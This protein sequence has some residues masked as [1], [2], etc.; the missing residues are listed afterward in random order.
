[1][2][3][4]RFAEYGASYCH[5]IKPSAKLSIDPCFNAVCFTLLVEFQVGS[6]Y[7]LI[8]PGAILAFSGGVGAVMK[9]GIKTKINANFAGWRSTELANGFFE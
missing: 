6:L 1:M 7:A 8:N 4:H 5:A 3:E 9:D 2:A